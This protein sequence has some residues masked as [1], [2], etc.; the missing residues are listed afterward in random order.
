M[1]F[2]IVRHLLKTDWLRLRWLVASCWILAIIAAWPALPTPLK[3]A[4]LALVG[5][6]EPARK[7]A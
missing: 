1:N 3:V 7:A 2:R 4:V 6:T 5:T